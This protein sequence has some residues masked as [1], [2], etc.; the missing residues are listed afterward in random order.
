[1]MNL[2][3]HF[4][5]TKNIFDQ[6]DKLELF[7]QRLNDL[8]KEDILKQV[9][10]SEGQDQIWMIFSVEDLEMLKMIIHSMNMSW[11]FEFEI[12]PLRRKNEKL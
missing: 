11:N 8:M 7:I 1:M 5:D 6:S 4:R 9:F 12:V 2:I 10:Q 3:V